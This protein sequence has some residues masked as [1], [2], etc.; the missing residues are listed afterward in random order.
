MSAVIF[1]GFIFAKLVQLHESVI[2]NIT[3]M[4]PRSIFEFLKP[5]KDSSDTNFSP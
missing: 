3:K 2:M 1:K 5:V 4:T